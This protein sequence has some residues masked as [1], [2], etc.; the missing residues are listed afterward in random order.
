MKTPKVFANETTY[1]KDC[2]RFTRVS[3][4]I[5]INGNL[6]VTEVGLITKLLS[7]DPSYIIN[8][9]T[10][11]VKSGLG[12]KAFRKSWAILEQEGYI[13]S[14]K[15][16]S[17]TGY[18]YEYIIS[19][20]P[21]GDDT[22]A[23]LSNQHESTDTEQAVEKNRLERTASKVPLNKDRKNKK[24]NNKELNNKDK[25]KLEI[26]NTGKLVKT[27]EG[28]SVLPEG[29]EDNIIHNI[30][31][32]TGSEGN[33][34]KIDDNINSS[35]IPEDVSGTIS[36][37][38]DSSV[39]S[40]GR[41]DII[42]HD[43][44]SPTVPEGN[45]DNIINNIIPSTGSEGGKIRIDDNINSSVI[46]E[47]I[48]YAPHNNYHIGTLSNTSTVIEPAFVQVQTEKKEIVFSSIQEEVKHKIRIYVKQKK[49]LPYL[50]K[51]DIELMYSISVFT[52]NSKNLDT[53]GLFQ[54][55]VRFSG[56]NN[57]IGTAS[58]NSIQNKIFRM[59]DEYIKEKNIDPA[60][61]KHRID[62]YFSNSYNN[63]KF[64]QINQNA[65]LDLQFEYFLGYTK[66]RSAKRLSEPEEQNVM[67]Q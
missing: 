61:A 34:I 52:E 31:P 64:Y 65:N 43:L 53:E 42:N 62:K 19:N 17:N 6:S 16:R 55:I 36:N 46:P 58:P 33:K 45:E 26:T 10:E 9:E 41:N 7:N 49:I 21:V 4:H 13:V 28:I 44:L 67:L 8:K 57:Y 47:G 50:V 29:N 27:V 39:I 22:Q 23:A 48:N 63:E 32:S 18:R 51:E 30:I 66:L 12:I 5:T 25:T 56:I 3:D 38:K 15:T 14:K 1:L 60:D 54:Y 24:L 40:E 2:K 37:S 11:Q 35:V 59:A 20:L